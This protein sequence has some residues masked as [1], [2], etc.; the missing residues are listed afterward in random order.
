MQLVVNIVVLAAIY[1]LIASGYVLIYRASRVL[2]LAHGELMLLGSYL[3]IA[4]ASGI[5]SSPVVALSI[6][7]ILSAVVGI[8]VYF[9]LIQRMTGQAVLAAVLPQPTSR[10]STTATS[11]P[12][13]ANPSAI[14]APVMPPPTMATSL[15]YDTPTGKCCSWNSASRAR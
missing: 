1:A 5:S 7:A 13:A 4:V 3:L 2:N 12:C 14:S 9:I 6:A 11:C 10:S 15:R 8:L